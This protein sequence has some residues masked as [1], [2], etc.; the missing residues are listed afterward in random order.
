[1]SLF[2]FA[3]LNIFLKT[4]N[5]LFFSKFFK[6]ISIRNK[7]H[8]NK[9]FTFFLIKNRSYLYCLVLKEVVQLVLQ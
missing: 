6:L 9:N 8:Q 3:F 5:N 7:K 2:I 4:A 1:M